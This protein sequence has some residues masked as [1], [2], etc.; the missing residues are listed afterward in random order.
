MLVS[1]VLP[2]RLPTVPW[3]AAAESFFSWVDHL[4][5]FYEVDRASMMH[6]L[7]LAQLKKHTSTQG[8]IRYTMRMSEDASQAVEAATGLTGLDLFLMTLPSLDMHRDSGSTFRRP[9]ET[10]A[11][12]PHCLAPEGRWP[13][14]WYEPWAAACPVHRC[15]LVSVCP[16]CNTPFTPER[17]SPHRGESGRCRGLGD[18]SVSGRT[19]GGRR[20][21][22]GTR[23][24][25]IDTT[26]VSDPYVLLAVERLRDSVMPPVLH[27]VGSHLSTYRVLNM[28]FD[29]RVVTVRSFRS[30]DPTLQRRFASQRVA[31]R[32]RGRDIRGFLD[33]RRMA[34]DSIENPLRDPISRAC[35]L[36][37]IGRILISADMGTTAHDLLKILHPSKRNRSLAPQYLGA[38]LASPALAGFLRDVFDQSPH[39]PSEPIRRT[40]QPHVP[41]RRFA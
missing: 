22:C 12:C 21:P 20:R 34:A 29:R 18:A 35:R 33:P 10:W 40:R 1:P 39:D 32:D 19:P 2:R 24:W 17:T 36:S 23:L 38:E 15:Y 3:P 11:F 8:L 37:V 6:A 27:A 28:L 30:P 26:P 25:E 14:W 7:G 13:L 4:S 5:Y 41:N 31:T 9:K 16:R